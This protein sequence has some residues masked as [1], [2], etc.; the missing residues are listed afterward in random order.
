MNIPIVGP[1]KWA[2]IANICYLWALSFYGWL[3]D[4]DTFLML[5]SVWTLWFAAQEAFGWI[6]LIAADKRGD[7]EIARTYSQIMQHFAAR[8]KGSHFL[9]TITGWDLF[10]TMNTLAAGGAAG[11][12]VYHV[13]HPA[14]GWFVG[15]CIAGWNYGHWHNRMRHG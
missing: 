10:V 12:I 2:W 14:F 15:I 6:R 9:A 3:V 5:G 8:D 13:W 7:P 4:R 11:Y 1:W